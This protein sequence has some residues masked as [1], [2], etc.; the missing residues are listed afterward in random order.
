MFLTV[1][2]KSLLTHSYQFYEIFSSI[3]PKYLKAIKTAAMLLAKL[4]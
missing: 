1:L 4:P 2:I 3:V